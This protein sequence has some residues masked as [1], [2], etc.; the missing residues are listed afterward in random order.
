LLIVFFGLGN[1]PQLMQAMSLHNMPNIMAVT[2]LLVIFAA[3]IN[4]ALLGI[5]R[6]LRR[7]SGESSA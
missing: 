4:T 3:I 6:R 7:R 5:D 1:L 2:L